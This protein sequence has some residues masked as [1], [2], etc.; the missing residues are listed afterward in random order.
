MNRRCCINR[1]DVLVEEAESMVNKYHIAFYFGL[2]AAP[3]AGSRRRGGVLR[4]P[5]LRGAAGDAGAIT[6]G[7]VGHSRNLQSSIGSFSCWK[8][9]F[10]LFRIRRVPI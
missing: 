4:W 1:S 3:L 2:A 8:L 6:A 7:A 9:Q 10:A 5:S